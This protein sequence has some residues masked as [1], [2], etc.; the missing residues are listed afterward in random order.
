[1]TNPKL[2]IRVIKTSGD[3]EDFDPN[4]IT[5]ECIEA[6]IEFFTAAEV[7]MEISQK[8]YD[9]ISTKEIKDST[10]E[11]LYKKHPESAELFKRFHSL[12]VRTS[13]NTIEPFD[14]KK[15][16]SSLIK[17]TNL[18]KELAELIS[19]ESEMEI[20]RLK[21]DFASSPL[22]REVV[23][24]K[25]LEHG[26]E[27]SRVDYTRLGI[28]VYD[29]TNLIGL[30]GND[31]STVDPELL[32]LHM[33]DS[34]FKEYTLLK[35]LPLY[36]TDAH[37]HGQ[38][39]IHDL[40]YFVSR[41]FSIE[42]DLRWF[43]EKGLELGTGKKVIT[44][45][46][47]D[48]P[49]LAFLIAAKVLYASKSDVSRKQVLK[50]FNVFLAPYVRGMDFKE[51]KQLLKLFLLESQIRT[52]AKIE[53]QIE[54]TCPEFLK[55]TLYENLEFEIK[56][57]ATAL[58]ELFLEG[59]PSKKMIL[60]PTPYYSLN[61]KDLN[62]DDFKDFFLQAHDLSSKFQ[63]SIFSRNLNKVKVAG[64]LGIITINLPRVAYEAKGD[65]Q[66]LFEI[67]NE[68][69]E[70]ARDVIIIKRDIIEQRLRR[71]QLPF[72]TQTENSIDKHSLDNFI[73][74]IG[75]VGINE[76][77]KVH[78]GNAIHEN[79]FAMNFGLKV[80]RKI[81]TKIKEWSRKT[82]LHW[83]LTLCPN[84]EVAFRMAKMDYSKFSGKAIVDFDAGGRAQYTSLHVN[85]RSDIPLIELLKIENKFH[86]LISSEIPLEISIRGLKSSADLMDLSM[87]IF[88][89]TGIKN[90]KFISDNPNK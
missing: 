82:G 59:D 54:Y 79:K 71:G 26:F 3:F 70:M 39:H 32:H 77:V 84:N 49:H 63:T 22:I 60:T 33:A 87:K 53:V 61:K 89:L 68:R 23:N 58:T 64:T 74:A 10:L 75:Y 12:L 56:T 43:F 47:A 17:E 50:H 36:L 51:I 90:W 37:M 35:V 72:L 16:T 20:R 8:I 48:N 44:T 14:R 31:I 76:L 1:M 69:L 65:D 83:T 21:L 57:I 24:V 2:D 73:H 80:L 18:P 7:A 85:P 52:T 5:E 29:A 62:K 15:I 66:K 78:T 45:G 19:K 41:P 11:V 6:G 30:K 38:I 42:H 25:L 34:I 28:P 9:G 46:P 40:D 81:S 67:L 13:R 4:V 27:E 55:D 88:D 86:S